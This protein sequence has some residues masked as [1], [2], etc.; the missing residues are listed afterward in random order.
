MIGWN[1]KSKLVFY[2]YVEEMDK[3]FKNGNKRTQNVKTGG[4]MT[5]ERY[6]SDILP[7]VHAR[8]I[9]VELNKIN[10]GHFIFQED[11]DGSHG[12]RSYEN[13][14]RMTKDEMELDFIEDHPPNSPDLNPIENVW[15]ILKSRVKLHHCKTHQELR[16]AIEEEWEAIT[17]QEINECILGSERSHKKR[18]PRGRK[19]G[20][21]GKSCHM[22]NRW[23]QCIDRNGLSTE[24]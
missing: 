2:A 24:F 4:A 21:K 18:D 3:E 23:Q 15:R 10:G 8:K 17:F 16:N 11:N 19:G 1:F 12:T 6:A 7:L 14:A 5:Q 9:D 22:R 20:A 13:I